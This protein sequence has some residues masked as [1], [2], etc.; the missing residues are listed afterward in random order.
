MASKAKASTKTTTK[1]AAKP[2]AKTAAKPKA[3]K[4][5]APKA[6]EPEAAAMPAPAH[7]PAASGTSIVPIVDRNP[8]GILALVL[9]IVGLG[10]VG[11]IIAGVK[12]GR[13]K[14]RDITF[15]VLQLV[16][17]FAGSLWGL[18]WGILIFVKGNK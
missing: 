12:D 17:L 15:G 18:V 10:G 4:A 16:I 13:H 9:G 6:S 2:A 5:P 11:T 1:T 14:G 8:W 7:T 3:A